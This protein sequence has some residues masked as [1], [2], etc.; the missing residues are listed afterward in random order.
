MESALA[1]YV[2]L[3][4]LSLGNA[5]GFVTFMPLYVMKPC[6]HISSN[7]PENKGSCSYLGFLKVGSSLR[8]KGITTTHMNS[9]KWLGREQQAQACQSSPIPEIGLNN[10][11]SMKRSSPSQHSP[12]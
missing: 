2:C 7:K 3:V 6:F 9:T 1:I 4:C 12:H 5:R 11:I 8:L 10:E